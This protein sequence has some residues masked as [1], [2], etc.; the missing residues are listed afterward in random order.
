VPREFAASLANGRA[1]ER[2]WSAPFKLPG[3]YIE[4]H[5]ELAYA[6]NV[7]VAQSRTV[8][9]THLVVDD[10][11]WREAFYVGMSRGRE[12]N[13]AYVMTE[14]GRAADLSPEPRPAP[15]LKDPGQHGEPPRPHRLAVLAGVLER[16]QTAWTATES[17]RQD[18]ERAA[19]LATLAPAWADVTRTHA[20]RRYENTI[21]SLLAAEDWQQY[22]QDS[23]RGTLAR[24]LRAADLAGH[25]VEAVLRRALAGR[26][27]A[28]ARSVAGC[29]TAGSAASP[30]RRNPWR[31]Q[32][33]RTGLR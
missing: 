2:L 17:V 26:D 18:L 28:G 24:L 3:D 13:T 9:T 25:D 30:A 5:A 4:Q 21:R 19:S 15:S 10:T 11:A 16:Q 8:D 27:F 33:M 6:G 14:R 22:T 31:P 23:E 20:T 12:R 29:C 32:V 1:G 7:H